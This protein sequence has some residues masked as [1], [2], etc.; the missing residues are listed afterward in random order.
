[1]IF[2]LSKYRFKVNNVDEVYYRYKSVNKFSY[3]LISF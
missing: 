2:R 1:M 3:T